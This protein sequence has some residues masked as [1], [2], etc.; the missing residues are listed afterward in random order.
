MILNFFGSP[1][2]EQRMWLRTNLVW[3]V[4]SALV[5]LLEI[6][7]CWPAD[8]RPVSG[9]DVA[10]DSSIA[11]GDNFFLYV[12]GNWLKRNPIPPEHSSWGVDIEL[13]DSIANSLHDILTDLAAK[14]EVAEPT[15]RKLRDFYLTA[16]DQRAIDQQG[17]MPL[18]P[19]LDRIAA[20]AS[21]EELAAEAGHLRK[22]GIDA[23]FDFSIS[24]DEKKS[25]RYAAHLTQ[26][27]MGLP[28][29]DYYLAADEDS[30]HIRA[31]YQDYIKKVFSLGGDS[32]AVSAAATEAVIRLEAKLAEHSR[33]P[34]DLRDQEANYH[35]MSV[36]E[37][38]ALAPNIQWAK[39]FQG[40]ADESQAAPTLPYAI[41]G[42]PEFFSHESELLASA[43]LADW[44]SYLRFQLLSQAAPYLSESFEQA[45]FGFYKQTLAGIKEMEPRWKRVL[46]RI[47][48]TQDEGT[49]PLGEA[50]GQLYVEKHFPPIAK[51]RAT[52]LVHNILD[53]YRERLESRDWL[54]AET[55]KIAVAKLA[56][57]TIK[58]GYPDHWRDYSELEIRRDSYV[59]NA[60]RASAFELAFWLAKLDQPVDKSLWEMTP[61]TVNCYYNP[62]LNEIVFPAGILQPPFYDYQADDA[63]NYGATGS[64]MGH[65]I[66]H[67]FD[68]QGSKYDAGGNLKDWWTAS[69]RA[70]FTELNEKLVKQFDAYTP[71]KGVHINGKLTLGENIA[72]L[73]GLYIS[74]FAYIKSLN[75]RTAPVM[76]GLT[77]PQRFFV[78]YARSWCDTRTQEELR[79]QLRTNEHA[80]DEYRVL[81]P[82]SN[83]TPFYDAFHLT[84]QNK[85]YRRPRDRVE[86]W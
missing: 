35:K 13:Q 2:F 77:G 6:D 76:N 63:V 37:L 28:E 24:Q 38:K 41:V 30:V 54:S 15:F 33:T 79:L 11:P 83:F 4:A 75:R 69:D 39:Y 21:I 5:S 14:T 81:G 48:G 78:A 27:G 51:Q 85:M 25:D 52:A 29:R 45:Q 36:A 12:N 86:I 84:P 64:T 70:R 71:L 60:F 19:E 74:Y 7:R 73:G 9:V 8:N 32:D 40:L 18:Q 49:H 26:G 72:D 17:V 80:P 65:E 57:V 16:I 22:L 34:T 59:Q 47:N 1:V 50:L 10:F 31:A 20:I 3:A 68:D 43:S 23:L 44:R 62:Q 67:G 42:Q 58:I 66:T 46:G 55:K 61:P 82:L 56:A 53:T